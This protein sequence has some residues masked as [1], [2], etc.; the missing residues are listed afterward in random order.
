MPRLDAT[1]AVT[2]APAVPMAT[3]PAPTRLRRAPLVAALVLL[4]A[5]C[6][7]DSGGASGAAGD[8]DEEVEE[9]VT[10][11]PTVGFDLANTRA[12]SDD[13]NLG[14]DT[15]GTLAPLWELDG[16]Q[17]FSSTPLIEDGVVY[18]GDWAGDLHALD[19]ATGDALWSTPLGEGGRIQASPALDDDRVFAANFAA[20]MYALD[21]ETGDVLWETSLDDHPY[22]S[23]FAAP[24]H[25]DG[26]VVIGIGS[27][28]NM[29]VTADD[30]SFRGSIVALDAETG[31]EQWRYWT[32]TGDD[33]EGAGVG[34]WTAPAVDTGRGALY[35][36]TGQH[37]AEPTSERSDAIIA[38]NLATGEEEWTYQFNEGDTWTARDGG[39]DHDVS[40]SPTLFE[41]DGRDVVASG[42]KGG[43]YRAVDRD[44]GEEVW[45]SELTEGSPQGGV[46]SGAAYADGRL[47]VLSNFEGQ[48]GGLFAL[49]AATG[50][51]VWTEELD[52]AA[53][54][55]VTWV[56]GV[57]FAADNSA[58][59]SAFSAEDGDLLWSHEVDEQSA[60]GF[61]V[62]DDTVY[63]GYGWWLAA[64]P[65][66]PVGGLIAFHLDGTSDGE[67]GDAGD[68]GEVDA[69]TLFGRS[70][71]SCHGADGSGANGPSLV[72]V[73]ERL[74]PDE[75]RSVI[76][77]GRGAMA[78]WEGRLDDDEVE[79]LVDYLE[80]L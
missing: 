45:V 4:V 72:D 55:P 68:T 50:E 12:V 1:D 79:A 15:V 20:D 7:D 67:A 54:G 59:L 57:V 75:R 17:G 19:A 33:E 28:E 8:P 40:A 73:S 60:T 23:A 61:A 70:C 64:P 43:T 71:A 48:A 31:D 34:V 53:M 76:L 42:D 56:N 65:E 14:P 47:F 37:H 26:L 3:H 9:V 49:D 29:I 25:V 77:E 11:W 2:T 18:G 36:G 16:I 21:R 44:T 10:S 69:A 22:A 27:Y 78:G 62:A 52:G 24:V 63:A 41:I 5:A 46:M 39:T 32:T 66:D 74:D 30:A 35:I 51:T 6:G 58:T 80:D 13:S 38:L